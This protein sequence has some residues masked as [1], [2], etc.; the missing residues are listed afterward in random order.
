MDSSR[1]RSCFNE[2][3]DDGLAFIA[4]MEL[5]AGGKAHY[6]L[7]R[8]GS[9]RNLSISPSSYSS[10][11]MRFGRFQEE[12]QNHPH[13]LEACF[14]CEKSLGGNKDIFMYRGDI[15][16]CSDDCRQEQ[17]EIEELKEKKSWN[18][19][20]GSLRMIRKGNTTNS[21]SP[22]K[23][24]PGSGGEYPFHHKGAVAA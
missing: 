9:F 23:S 16:F 14:L 10:S 24:R 6:G 12:E 21:T 15:P 17:M 20:N 7:Q 19:N 1:R 5:Q 4:G 22:N 18:N 13:F 2:E 11:S 8:R 3:D